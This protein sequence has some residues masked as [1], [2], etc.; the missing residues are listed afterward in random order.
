[1]PVHQGYYQHHPFPRQYP[2]VDVNIFTKSVKS[3]RLLMDQG[4]IL[5]DRL[6]DEDFDLKIMA[7]AQQGNKAEVNRLI[8]S[9][10]LKVPVNTKYTPTSITFELTQ[11]DPNTPVNC[12]TLA[13]NMKWGN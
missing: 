10:G 4:S 6:G 3:F 5:L 12:C 9:I 7:A 8:K 1:M 2:P 13:V 11:P